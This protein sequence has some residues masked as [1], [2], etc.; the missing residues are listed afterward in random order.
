MTNNEL[1]LFDPYER[2]ER[3]L[4]SY[5]PLND[6]EIYYCLQMISKQQPK[7]QNWTFI[8]LLSEFWDNK[9]TLQIDLT[10]S[11]LKQAKNKYSDLN[12]QMTDIEK[13]R[14]LIKTAVNSIVVHTRG[15]SYLNLYGYEL[16]LDVLESL[17]KN[18]LAPNEVRFILKQYVDTPA[19]VVSFNGEDDPGRDLIDIT[20]APEPGQEDPIEQM[21]QSMGLFRSHLVGR[22]VVGDWNLPL[23]EILD[24]E[25]GVPVEKLLAKFGGCPLGRVNKNGNDG[26][27]KKE[28]RCDCLRRSSCPG[29]RL[30]SAG[31]LEVLAKKIWRIKEKEGSIKDLFGEFKLLV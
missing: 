22:V 29:G 18:P 23:I 12:L 15:P 26:Y 31:R 25:T 24:H 10:W 28:S 27:D 6:L 4:K 17:L 14:N 21:F 8:R 5:S 11:K 3:L 9:M 1:L 13:I 20:P 2:V 30:L 16:Q 19:R 7:D